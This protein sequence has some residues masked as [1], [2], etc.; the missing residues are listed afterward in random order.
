VSKRIIVVDDCP[1][2]VGAA[3]GTASIDASLIYLKN[4]HPSG[5]WP[6][7]VRNFGFDA[8]DPLG[9]KGALRAFPG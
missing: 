7:R 3:D 6:G 1:G 2:W 9:D 5:G 4:P 8:A